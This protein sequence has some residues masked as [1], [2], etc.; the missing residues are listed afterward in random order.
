VTVVPDVVTSSFGGMDVVVSRDGTLG[1][2]SVGAAAGTPRTLVWVDRM[3][4]ETEVGMPPRPYFL[5]SVSPDGMRIAVFANDQEADIWLWELARTTLSR[6]TSVPGRDVVQVWTPDGRRVIFSSER[7]G[8]RNLFWQT[9]DGTGAAEPLLESAHTEYPMA[10]SPDGRQLIFTDE[11]PQTDI[12]LMALEL[13]GTRRVSPLLQTRFTERNG[14]ISPDGH[15]LA[16]EANDSGRFEIYV[17]PYPNVNSSLSLVSTNGGTKPLWA[18]NGQELF[19]VP[20]TGALMRVGVTPGSSSSATKPS[21]VV[22]EGFLPI[23]SGGAGPTMCLLMAG[24][25]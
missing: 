21:V 24:D 1:Y 3:G 11:S 4:N 6:L 15:W 12:D 2:L 19:Y 17:W 10:V 13:D 16:Y 18:R 22:K 14:V 7:A 20:P 5:P 23:R 25:S 9:A 8:D